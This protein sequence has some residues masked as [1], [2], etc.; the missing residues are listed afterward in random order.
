MI[1]ITAIKEATQTTVTVDGELSR[2]HVSAVETSCREAQSNGKPVQ[3]FL[4]DVTN[5]DQAGQTLLRRLAAMGI[6]L[7]ANGVYTSY[8]VQELGA[9]NGKSFSTWLRALK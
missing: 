2:E 6:G 8:L 3:L 7:L 5:V 4:R 1:R 9:Q